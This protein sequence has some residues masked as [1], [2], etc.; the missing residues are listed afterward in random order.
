MTATKIEWTDRTWNPGLVELLLGYGCAP[1]GLVLDVFAGG[2]TTLL[3]AR[4][5]GR[6]AVGIEL[7]EEQCA[8]TVE[9]RLSQTVL[10]LDGGA[11]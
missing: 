5:S 7:R 9:H 10:P 1:G 4:N 8:S 3:A 6:R 11:A 2:G